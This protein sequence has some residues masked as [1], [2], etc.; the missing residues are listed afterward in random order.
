MRAVSVIPGQQRSVDLTELAEP[1]AADGPVLVKTR[2]IGVCG[3]DLEIIA[4]E[5]G[6]APPGEKR[7][8]I[9]H[10]SLGE[11]LEAP[12]GLGLRPATWWWHRPPPGPG[13]LPNC[14]IGEWDMCR[15]GHYT[16]W[17]IKAPTATPRSVTASPR[18][19]RQG[20]PPLGDLGVLLEPTTV[21][22]KAWDH[23]ERIGTRAKW[24]PDDG[25]GHRRRPHRAAGRAA[26]VQRGS[27]VTCS[28]RS[29]GPEAGPGGRLG[30]PRT[31][32]ATCRRHRRP[33]MSSSS[34]RASAAHVRRHGPQRPQRIVC[35]TGVSSAGGCRSTR[36]CS[37]ATWS[38]KTTWSFGSVNANRR[39]Y[40]AGAAL[41]KADPAWLGGAHHPAGPHRPAGPMP[42]RVS[43]DDIKTVLTF[44]N[45]SP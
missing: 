38:W 3:T 26:G 13:A 2:A 25:A 12:A 37:T 18:F 10:E 27:R 36:A 29:P 20:R 30:R 32:T 15:N 39:H 35:L 33:P 44:P 17:G 34:A 8:A 1:P 19:R 31:T 45:G 16:E 21:V 42:T 28:T 9:G 14:A 4:G 5:Y 24:E 6:W 11:V 7:L 43:P 23:I 41:A 22:A 40:E